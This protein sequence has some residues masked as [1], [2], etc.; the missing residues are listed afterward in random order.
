[1]E[2]PVKSK[3]AGLVQETAADRDRNTLI[4]ET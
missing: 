1:M 3:G 2:M 4:T